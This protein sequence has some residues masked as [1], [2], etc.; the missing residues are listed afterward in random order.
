MLD[1]TDILTTM[2]DKQEYQD[3][4]NSHISDLE[5]LNWNLDGEDHNRV[6]EIMSELENIVEV[7]AENREREEEHGINGELKRLD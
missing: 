6:K 3:R 7:A 5:K 1:Q 4:W 2:V